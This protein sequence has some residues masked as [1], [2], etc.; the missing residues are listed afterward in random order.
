[1]HTRVRALIIPRF[2][3][4]QRAHPSD[5]ERL[6][7]SSA[8]RQ[9]QLTTR[10][11]LLAL[12]CSATLGC[13][14]PPREAE[15]PVEV[16]VTDFAGQPVEGATLVAGARTVS[17]TAADG[18]A[19]LMLPGRDGDL[20]SL[21]VHCPEGYVAPTEPLVIRWLAVDSGLASHLTRCRQLR[22]RLV[23]L[24][25]VDGGPG[26]PIVRLGRV[27]GT[28]DKAGATS[29][30]FDLAID[31]RLELVLSTESLAKEK[32]TPRDP[33]AVFELHDADEIKLFDVKLARPKP[34]PKR[35]V[36]ARRGPVAM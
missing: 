7:S 22:H 17:T 8:M 10:L 4:R 3:Q 26:L 6:A 5:G 19:K 25:R 28:T 20:F 35:A 18:V 13:S 29:L 36:G 16:R 12:A 21:G 23:V 11:S 24:V 32:V 2:A 9:T 1:M 30:M 34:Q 27:V 14:A 15:Q 31:E 33:S